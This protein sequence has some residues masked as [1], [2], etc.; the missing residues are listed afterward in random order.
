[1][2]WNS[3]EGWWKIWRHKL[4]YRSMEVRV[5]VHLGFQWEVNCFEVGEC[6]DDILDSW[7]VSGGFSTWHP[8]YAPFHT[9]IYL[10]WRFLAYTNT[11]DLVE[12]LVR[13][14]TSDALDLATGM[15]DVFF[16]S[17]TATALCRSMPRR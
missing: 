10:H 11:A 15:A 1:M 12:V 3:S 17:T 4:R 16:N 8:F 9:S 13:P 5:D 2:S 14:A 7:R 6:P